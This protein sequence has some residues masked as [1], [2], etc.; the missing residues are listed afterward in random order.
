MLSIISTYLHAYL[1]ISIFSQ[2]RIP[3]IKN[4]RKHMAK[5][6]MNIYYAPAQNNIHEKGN[7][8]MEGKHQSGAP[9]PSP[10]DLSG[11]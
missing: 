8:R 3:Q 11:T 7:V 10:P 6:F 1:E 5:V 2:I 4:M 9:W